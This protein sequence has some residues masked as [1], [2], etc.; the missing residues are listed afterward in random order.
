MKSKKRKIKLLMV[1]VGICLLGILV[2]NPIFAA[3][4][5]ATVVYD[6]TMKGGT[7]IPSKCQSHIKSMGYTFNQY[8][9]P[10]H[11][12]VV[13]YMKNAKV[14]VSGLHGAP[15]TINCGN[16]SII[17]A[18]GS[19]NSA[20]AMSLNTIAN[21][22]FSNMKIALI[23]GCKTG[24]PDATYGDIISMI[25]SKGATCAIGWK[26]TTYTARVSEWNRLFFEKAKK[27]T[28]VESIRHA[29]YW[30]LS[31]QGT[32]AHNNMGKRNEKGTI[33]HTIY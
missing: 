12:N 9:L 14:F 24:E 2:N 15:G 20:H 21:G 5:N 28:V 18:K 25:Q 17:V 27:D 31:L 16:N 7:D 19:L 32:D 4:G 3:T 22:S 1:L 10:K 30:L 11:T 33:T 26:E 13:S 29:D 23:Y 6:S 8:D